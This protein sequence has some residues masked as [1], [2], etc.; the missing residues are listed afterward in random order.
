MSGTNVVE[1]KKNRKQTVV[2]EVQ[3]FVD[4]STHR[5]LTW[6]FVLYNTCSSS[7]AAVII[8]GRTV[9]KLASFPKIAIPLRIYSQIPVPS[10]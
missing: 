5:L 2:S 7:F 1:K 10:T 9:G 6:T 4:P 3:Y 8:L